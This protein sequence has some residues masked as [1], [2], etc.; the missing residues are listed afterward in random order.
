MT[1]VVKNKT[2]KMREEVG[3]PRAAGPDISVQK[4]LEGKSRAESDLKNP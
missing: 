2:R 4:R 3:L 1:S